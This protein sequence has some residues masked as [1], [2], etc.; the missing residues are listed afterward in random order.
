MSIYLAFFKIV[1]DET[2]FQ[3]SWAEPESFSYM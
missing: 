2:D 1:V 3:F